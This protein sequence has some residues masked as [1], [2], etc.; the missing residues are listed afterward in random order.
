MIA[1]DNNHPRWKDTIPEARD[2]THAQLTPVGT[3][4]SGLWRSDAG[5]IWRGVMEPMLSGLPPAKFEPWVS[6]YTP[7]QTTSRPR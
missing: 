1:I 4:I 7:P 6:P 5:V 2:V 3:T